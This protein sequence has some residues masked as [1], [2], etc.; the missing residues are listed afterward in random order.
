[1]GSNP[2]LAVNIYV[3]HAFWSYCS[4]GECNVC[5][6]P[7]PE[8]IIFTETPIE[9]YLKRTGYYEKFKEVWVEPNSFGWPGGY[10]KNPIGMT[11]DELVKIRKMLD[12]E[13]KEL[14]NRK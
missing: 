13:Y 12:N 2:I 10:I 6:T 9:A 8:K 3:H 1:M 11:G 7:S 5:N 4:G 14:E